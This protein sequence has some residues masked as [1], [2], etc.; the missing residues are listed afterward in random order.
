MHNNGSSQ[1]CRCGY[2]LISSWLCDGE[3]VLK[4]VSDA[5]VLEAVIFLPLDIFQLVAPAGLT[6]GRLR[7]QCHGDFLGGFFLPWAFFVCGCGGSVMA[8]GVVAI[9]CTAAVV[10]A[11][12]WQFSGWIFL[13]W[14]IFVG[15]CGDSVMGIFW[16][17]FLPWAFFF[18]GGGTTWRFF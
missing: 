12:S 2:E 17:D 1:T 6:C 8:A 7:W 18:V 3:R 15:C 4:R 14:N 11:V 13:P 9:F 5:S 10:V 16:V